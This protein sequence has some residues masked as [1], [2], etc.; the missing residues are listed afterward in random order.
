MSQRNPGIL[1]T[2]HRMSHQWDKNVKK[3]NEQ[4]ERIKPG[5]IAKKKVSREKPNFTMFK[6]L[7][8]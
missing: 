2:S 4:L 1:V 5:T 6:V 7:A 3:V 8:Y